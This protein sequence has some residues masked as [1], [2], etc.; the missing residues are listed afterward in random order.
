MEKPDDIIR[1][2]WTEARRHLPFFYGTV[3]AQ[4]ESV[5]FDRDDITGLGI[6]VITF[7]SDHQVLAEECQRNVRWLND[8]LSRGAGEL[9]GLDIVI[10]RKIH[11]RV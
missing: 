1:T 10:P 2:V 9:V 4:A 11:G 8:A 3:L 6:F 7:S 5:S